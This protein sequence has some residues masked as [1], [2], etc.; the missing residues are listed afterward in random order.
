MN[1][2][3]HP[4]QHDIGQELI[5]GETAFDVSPT[6]TP[7]PELLDDP[8]GQIDRGVGEAIGQRLGF[9]VLDPLVAHFF[10]EPVLHLLEILGLLRGGLSGLTDVAEQPQEVQMETVQVLGKHGREPGG[11]LGPD[12]ASMGTEARV[13]EHVCH[14]GGKQV[15][16]RHPVEPRLLRAKRK[17]VPRERRGH[18]RESVP[19]ITPKTGGVS[20]ARQEFMEFPD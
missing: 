19:G 4:V 13:A 11:H 3:G 16:H 8:G 1:S 20:Q 5:L 14:Q 2:A 6:V 18:D 12:I 7:A 10:R 9:R 15:G 17:R